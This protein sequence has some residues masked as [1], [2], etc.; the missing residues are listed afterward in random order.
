MMANPG[1]NYCTLETA[2]IEEGEEGGGDIWI[3]ELAKMN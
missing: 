3:G 2:S 1:K